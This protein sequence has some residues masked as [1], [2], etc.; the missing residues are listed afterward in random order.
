MLIAYITGGILTSLMPPSK[1][2]GFVK[3]RKHGC[4][5]LIFL[6]ILALLALTVL[7]RIS[8]IEYFIIF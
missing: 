1:K 7:W 8:G 5:S 4:C 6:I 3:K 2:G